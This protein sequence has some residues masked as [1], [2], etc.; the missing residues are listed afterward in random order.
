MSTLMSEAVPA[1][2]V[3]G[4]LEFVTPLVGFED[5]TSFRLSSLEANGLIW[6]LESTRSPGLRFIVAP[7]APFFPDYDPLID[8]ESVAGLNV[9]AEELSLLVI[10]TVNGSIRGATANL[11]APVI[12]A[13][14]RGRAL[15]VVLDDDSLPLRAPLAVGSIA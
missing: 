4:L 10:L 14:G 8:E 13:P 6:S 2:T 9:P 7:P 3:D 15:Q 11:L 12:F 1:P 5:E